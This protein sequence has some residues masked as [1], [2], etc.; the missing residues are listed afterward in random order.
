MQVTRISPLTKKTNTQ[1]LDITQEQ[2]DNYQRGMLIQRAF[3]NL[4]SA[5]R[6][7][8]KSGMTQEDWDKV[9]PK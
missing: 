9:F 3:P 2:I 7:F 5:D 4:N 8:F 1:E 6:E